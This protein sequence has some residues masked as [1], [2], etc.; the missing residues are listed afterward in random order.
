MNNKE[1]K[2]GIAD[3]KVARREG[4]L[5]THALGSCIGITLYDPMIKL[6]AL[7]HI[8]LPQATGAKSASVFRFADTGI[9]E[10]LRKLSAFGG[11]KDRYICKIAGGAQMFAVS[12]GVGSIG[13]IGQRNIE[14]VRNVLKQ[15]GIRIKNQDV[16]GNFAR[17]MLID[18]STGAVKLRTIGKPE[19]TL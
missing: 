7:I 3:M 19:V 2:V 17:T 1:I 4:I 15:E 18:V 12:G 6:G 14:S 9:R 13:N 16:G 8:M 10:T 11:T 5:I